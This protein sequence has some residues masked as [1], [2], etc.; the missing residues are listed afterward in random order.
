MSGGKDSPALDPN[1]CPLTVSRG[2]ASSPAGGPTA[3]SG[4]GSEKRVGFRSVFKVS[5]RRN[6]FF[7]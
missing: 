2:I 6:P 1:S 7:K 4:P 3:A 5:R